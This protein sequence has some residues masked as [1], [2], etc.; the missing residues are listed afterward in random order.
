MVR[1]HLVPVKRQ[2]EILKELQSIFLLYLCEKAGSAWYHVSRYHVL[3]NH[4]SYF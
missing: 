1:L 3:L 4:V 2:Y